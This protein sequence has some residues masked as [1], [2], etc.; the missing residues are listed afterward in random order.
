[1]ISVRSR[2][3]KQPQHSVRVFVCRKSLLQS[4]RATR[5]EQQS[6]NYILENKRKLY[7]SISWCWCV[8][9]FVFMDA[10]PGD[11][12]MF[13]CRPFLFSPDSI[14]FVCTTQFHLTLQIGKLNCSCHANNPQ[15]FSAGFSIIKTFV[16]FKFSIDMELH[17]LHAS[18]YCDLL[19]LLMKVRSAV[20]ECVGKKSNCFELLNHPF[21]FIAC[22][23]KF[24]YSIPPIQHD[25]I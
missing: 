10:A 21:C 19:V 5:S 25:W 24:L 14:H 2:V 7:L 15:P 8:L 1:M 12:S 9:S 4:K 3:H 22:L 6:S 23:V 16:H 17:S 11:A 18:S 13:R 20:R